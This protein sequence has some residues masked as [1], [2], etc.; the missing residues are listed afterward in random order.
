MSGL[1]QKPEMM[2]PNDPISTQLL[3]LSSEIKGPIVYDDSGFEVDYRGFLSDICRLRN[4]LQKKLPELSF[5]ENGLFTETHPNVNI[6][7]T[8]GYEF[9]VAFFAVLTLGGAALP[10]GQFIPP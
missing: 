8:G 3:R 1:P 6:L 4:T 9:I 7:S 2:F 5:G 10:L